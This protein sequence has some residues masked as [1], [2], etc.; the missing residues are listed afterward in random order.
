[1]RIFAQSSKIKAM[2]PHVPSPIIAFSVS[3]CPSLASHGYSSAWL[4]HSHS[5]RNKSKQLGWEP[6]TTQTPLMSP[7]FF[8][9]NITHLHSKQSLWS[10]LIASPQ[11]K[12]C[13][14]E[15]GGEISL[16]SGP[17]LGLKIF[18]ERRQRRA[19]IRLPSALSSKWDQ[20]NKA[21]HRNT[22][23]F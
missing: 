7:A 22:D 17:T 21:R 3:L 12:K 11:K 13:R 16:N 18:L 6:N 1:M 20:R 2:L 9:G 8:H 10:I 14:G 19:G 5:R 23:F 4:P 15:G